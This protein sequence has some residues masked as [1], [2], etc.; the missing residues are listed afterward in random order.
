MYN[1]KAAREIG[2]PQAHFFWDLHKSFQLAATRLSI[3]I[4]IMHII[5]DNFRSTTDRENKNAFITIT[6]LRGWI[7]FVKRG[8]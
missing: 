2:Q 1:K 8:W 7:G 4:S 5:M 6:S 3:S